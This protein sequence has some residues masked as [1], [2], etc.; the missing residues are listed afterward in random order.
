M[1][2]VRVTFEPEGKTV[3]VREGATLLDAARAAGVFLLSICGGD[4][5]CGRC[6]VQVLS[7][8]VDAEPTALLSR[9][10]IRDGFV[11][12]CQTRVTEDVEVAVPPEARGDGAQIL[13]DEDARRFRALVPALGVAVEYPYAP[14][15]SKLT[16]ELSPPTLQDYLGCKER[17]YRE[18]RRRV[19]APRMQMGLKVLQ[20][21][22]QQ[23]RDAAWQITA[24]LGHRGDT[25]EVIQIE[26]GNRTDAA[27]GIVVDIGTSTVVA[28]LVDLIASRTLDA[29]A[30]YNSQIPYGAEVT[31]RIIHAER[32][33]AGPMRDAVIGDINGLINTLV[34]RSNVELHDV[35]ACF[36]SGN[37]TML[38]FLL[39]LDAS[40]IRK[41]PYV[42]A[43][44][45]PPPVRAVEVGIRINPRG[46]LYAMSAIG[47][48]VG[49]DIT[50]G[51]LATGLADS[52][53][54]T[55][56]VDVGTNGEIVLGNRDWMLA[57]ATS[58]GPAFE[59]TGVRCGMRASRGAI[60]R[61]AIAEDGSIDLE[62]IGGGEPR[63]ICGSGLIDAIAGLFEAGILDRA[64]R[65]LPD[66][67]PRVREVDGRM[68]FVLVE[69]GK[70][71]ADTD[72]VVTQPD[73][74]NVLRA[75]A[76]IYA[77]AK[78]LLESTERT[79]ADVQQLLI[80]GGFGNYLDGRKA[81]LL[82]MIPDIPVERIHFVGNTSV[83]GSKM[84]LLSTDALRRSEEIARSATYYDLIT[85]PDYYEEFMSAKFLPHTDLSL[86][87]SVADA[88]G[89]STTGKGRDDR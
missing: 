67:S 70:G 75:K 28:H 58:A 61:V 27:Y 15:V 2:T 87:P 13:V 38:H 30:C 10:E 20:S 79:F 66:R 44:T 60:E 80:A 81:V 6:R 64:G 32:E 73:I 77:G 7:G 18:I 83:I 21:L 76:A 59:G 9:E 35:I 51:I 48:W 36:A 86:F 33:G 40:H 11:L 45:N 72:I 53:G 16:V 49:G 69:A 8:V 78:I 47:G 82:G 34:T 22:P 43:A 3:D 37:T 4:G 26:E 71:R 41:S 42:P 84:A 17:L 1:G 68:E 89:T 14:I 63:G 85:Y 24:T 54:L 65:L 39:G 50:A 23:H 46:I 12:A 74:E 29:E 52:D 25:I 56:L 55:M 62:T 88:V 5:I 19:D 31:R 57:C